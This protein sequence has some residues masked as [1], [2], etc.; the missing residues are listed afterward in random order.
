MSDMELAAAFNV[1]LRVPP[2]AQAEQRSVLQQ[3]GAFAGTD[4]SAPAWPRVGVCRDEGTCAV[5]PGRGSGSA[6]CHAAP[7]S[8]CTLAAPLPH[9]ST[10][11]PAHH[12][13]LDAAVAELPDPEVPIKRLLLLLD[14]ARQ[15]QA[16][17]ERAVPLERWSAVLRDLGVSV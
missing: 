8:A 17:E 1:A 6:A 9:H 4:V 13:Q 10:P 11:L 12:P 3:L 5:Q 14:L 2:L 16:D 7:L 15:G